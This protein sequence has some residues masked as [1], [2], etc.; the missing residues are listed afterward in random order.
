MGAPLRVLAPWAV[1]LLALQLTGASHVIH[2]S[3]EDEP[4]PPSVPA[5][6]ISPLLRTGYHFQPPRNWIN[7]MV[8]TLL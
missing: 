5:S 3:L 2:R 8:A 7:G 4:A 6:I 1:L